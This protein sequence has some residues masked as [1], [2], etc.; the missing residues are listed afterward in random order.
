MYIILGAIIAGIV[1][2]PE[3]AHA[4]DTDYTVYNGFLPLFNS[5]QRL[6][7]ITSDAN[8]KSLYAVGIVV[9]IFIAG[10]MNAVKALNG[11]SS[12]LAWAMPVLAG[13]TVYMAMFSGTGTIHLYDPVLNKTGDIGR[14]PVGIIAIARVT[15][16]IE[17]GFVDMISTAG[18]PGSYDTN[19]GGIGFSMLAQT[20]SMQASDPDATSS[21]GNFVTDCVL[22]EISRPGT[23][24]TW[25]EVAT[26][27]DLWGTTLV[28][29]QNPAVFTQS[30]LLGGSAT[31]TDAFTSLKSYYANPA[32]MASMKASMCSQAG[33][34]TTAV[35][36]AQCSAAF[37]S[38]TTL[39]AGS[40]DS[41]ES[42]LAGSEVSEMFMDAIK[43][44]SPMQ[45]S[46]LLAN[47][48]QTTGVMSGFAAAANLPYYKAV[49]TAAMFAFLPVI[50][51]FVPTVKC[52]AAMS[53][54]FGMFI[55]LTS[56]SIAD[57]TLNGIMMDYAVGYFQGVAASG[58]SLYYYLSFPNNATLTMSQ[59]G[60]MR[61]MA[62]LLAGMVTAILTR[63]A[64]ALIAGTGT[65]MRD[66]KNKSETRAE[67]LSDPNAKGAV[68][69]GLLAG[70]A[71]MSNFAH[72]SSR[73]LM[74]AVE[75][76][77]EK[78][79]GA[80]GFEESMGARAAAGGN[81]GMYG[82]MAL[83]KESM[84]LAEAGQ[85]TVAESQMLGAI[86]GGAA[87]A[88]LNALKA[89]G[90][91]L[92]QA[93][94]NSFNE[95][96]KKTESN[97]KYGDMVNDYAR[98]HGLDP[99]NPQQRAKAF[100]EFAAL[101]LATQDATSKVWG[102]DAKGY[103]QFLQDT[104][105][106][107]KAERSSLV[108]TASDAGLSLPQ[109]AGNKAMISAL[110]DVGKIQATNP[111]AVLSQLDKNMTEGKFDAI[112]GDRA[113]IK[114]MS[115]LTGKDQKDITA[116]DMAG[117]K[118]TL[119][120]WQKDPAGGEGNKKLEDMKTSMGPISAE[121][122]K[123]MGRTGILGE[124][125]KMDAWKHLQDVKGMDARQAT[126]FM[127]THKNLDNVAKLE[128][129]DAA[130]Q[131]MGDMAG[132][133][134]WAGMAKAYGQQ[135]GMQERILSAKEAKALNA[136][137]HKGGKNS[138]FNAKAGDQARF[139][140]DASTKTLG[141]AISSGGGKSDHYNLDS[142]TSGKDWQKVDRDTS[143]IDKGIRSKIGNDF[144]S[145]NKKIHENTDL[146]VID[147]GLRSKI[148]KQEWSGETR[149]DEHTNISTSADY[150]KVDRVLD[151]K[152]DAKLMQAMNAKLEQQHSTQKVLPGMT[153]QAMYDHSGNLS[154]W[155]IKEGGKS[156]ITDLKETTTGDRSSTYDNEQ[157][158][159][160][161]TNKT[162]T[163]TGD[164]KKVAKSMGAD[165]Q[166]ADMLAAVGA[167][168]DDV[169]TGVLKYAAVGT[170]FNAENRKTKMRDADKL[171]RKEEKSADKVERQ[172]EK[173]ADKA[174]RM[175]EK[176]VEEG[177]R[178][179]EKRQQ[180]NQQG[181]SR[182]MQQKA[183]TDPLPKAH[184]KVSPNVKTATRPTPKPQQS[185]APGG[186][187]SAPH[188]AGANSTP[189][190][191]SSAPGKPSM[192]NTSAPKPRTPGKSM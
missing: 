4:M 156:A 35:G 124:A 88:G 106:M 41:P 131:L 117:A 99:N 122:L 190:K 25:N 31:C 76:G 164:I 145:G 58:K 158:F 6:A 17:V 148:G 104:Q 128:N 167:T 56:W 48:A 49:Y 36:L 105:N 126:E 154:S 47:K 90:D 134:D 87:V 180:Q 121:D 23:T 40:G 114:A 111:N 5:F 63:S 160:E 9:S 65:A 83:K 176:A 30:A 53:A 55:M 51:I 125:G 14:V 144:W 146:E 2:F 86:S 181:S 92:Q 70:H 100:G 28:K 71:G 20:G 150:V 192:P 169:A 94:M 147:K 171:E 151:A 163:T 15:N 172:E 166:T 129:F 132:K 135:D 143:V 109:F 3:L 34:D 115:A 120:A 130:S 64:S 62:M 44:A 98:D 173:A 136:Q 22:F 178:A 127:D 152:K 37:T 38:T 123:E 112:K 119:G 1:G 72:H 165:Q 107:S 149:I 8:F 110:Q 59:F 7:L 75:W 26:T 12:G 43:S 113:Q 79:H 52:G 77:G 24:L 61:P 140:Y 189:V 11:K 182:A 45:A 142:K 78:I 175:R 32:N 82:D 162:G 74:T 174:E 39:V 21:L 84:N 89:T 81:A 185:G 187:G 50:I 155:D 168:A 103:S 10:A 157:N 66:I 57:A 177:R 108:K 95:T 46:A 161:G 96:M 68:L 133:G 118:T 54:I 137:M 153:F 33:F 18:V 29:A 138:N 191:P 141:M 80:K 67:S 159:H 85:K 69:N 93:K 60:Y 101:D 184:A 170:K 16:S 179:L 97:E 42:Y 13:I 91:P 102:S 19:A 73:D 27:S 139:G 188:P 183:K 116:A 186:S